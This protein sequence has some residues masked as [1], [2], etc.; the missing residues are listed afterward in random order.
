[1]SKSEVDRHESRLSFFVLNLYKREKVESRIKWDE[2]FFAAK[3]PKRFV[4]H[5]WK[6][7]AS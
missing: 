7:E 5:A 6:R 2:E 1:M 4:P 3:I